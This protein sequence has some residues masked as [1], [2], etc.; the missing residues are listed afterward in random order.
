M[1]DEEV[2]YIDMTKGDIL[3]GFKKFYDMATFAP[4]SFRNSYE[5]AANND[6]NREQARIKVK[7]TDANILLIAGTED[8]MWQSDVAAQN[9]YDKRPENF[10]VLIYEGAGHVFF[11]DWYF[12]AGN[13]NM[14]LGG[15]IK[16]NGKA[17][18]DSM[19]IIVDRLEKW[20]SQD[21]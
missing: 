10:E 6:P 16:R 13:M 15:D 8:M 20:H 18:H 19:K 7:D 1:K 5:S 21:N 11:A 4:V 12:N 17:G 2:S 14:A 3:S 9:I